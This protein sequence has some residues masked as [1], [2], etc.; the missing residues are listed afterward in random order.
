VKHLPLFFDLQ[1]RRVVVVGEGPMAERRADLARSGGAAV[2][3]VPQVSAADLLGAAA[4]F[5]ATG[6]ADTDTEAQHAARVARVP[7]N[8][9][10]RP[11]LS[12]FILPAI[13]D[14]DEVVVAVSTGGAS[15]TLATLLRERIEALLPERVG[16]LAGLARMFRAQANTLIGDAGARRA[17]WRRFIAGPAGRLALAGDEAGARRAALGELDAARRAGPRQGVAHIVGAGPGDPDLLTLK[18]AQLLQ[19]ADAILHD[20]LVPAAILKRARREAELVPVGKR[21]G[22][23]GWRQA[24]IEAEMI[25]RVRAGQTVVRLKAGDPFVF[26]RGAEEVD[27]LQA[28]G[29]TVTVVPGITAALGCAAAIGVPL[30][31][32]RVASAITIVSGHN[33]EGRATAWP[34][35]AE[36]HT[37]VVYMGAA[38][39]TS[40]RDRLLDAGTA[41]QTPIAIVEN[42]TR[43]DQRVSTGRLADLARLAAG[44]LSRADAG[45]S[46]I[47]VGAAA[48]RARTAHEPL[49]QVS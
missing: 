10:D 16:A 26:G 32:R 24:D 17:F 34:A 31:D 42:G 23:S 49:V 46:L 25:R 43:P 1:G 33:A 29:L 7:V 44:H 12:D 37:L 27:A 5:V 39:A 19:E 2:Y 8:V 30:T 4:V 35:V 22:G 48:A 18:A 3:Q 45:P 36:G 47:I 20:A 28:A 21:R 40:V 9:A 41:P 6:D 13:V 38:E 11:A 15:P 14:R